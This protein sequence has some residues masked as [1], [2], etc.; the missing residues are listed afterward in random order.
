[1]G[2]LEA[3]QGLLDVRAQVRE[4]TDLL[5]DLIGLPPGTCLELVDPLPA[6]LPVRCG[7]DAAAMALAGSPEVREAA[8]Q[9]AKAEAAHQVACMDY[10]PD[11]NVIGGYANQTSADYIQPNIGYVGLTGTFTFW[12]WGKRRDVKRQ[13]QTQ[14]SLAHQNLAVVS[15]RVQQ[16]AR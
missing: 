14:I 4:L 7:E 11:V 12:D 16:E 13:R 5:N 2:L 6:D 10:L 9:I 3:R 15:D 8:Q 1:I